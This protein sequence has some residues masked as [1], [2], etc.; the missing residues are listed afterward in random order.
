MKDGKLGVCIVGC[1]AMGTGH[2]T[3]WS[4]VPE[5][6]VVTVVDIDEQR[7]EKLAQAHDLDTWYADYR[8]AVALDEVEVV[9]VCIPTCLHPE[10]TVFAA[11]HGKHVLSEKP[12]ALTLEDA[13]AMIEAARRNGVKLGVGF[14]RRHSPVLPEL[15][16][17]LAE[18]HLGRPVMYHASDIREI[19][20]KREMH[21]AHANGGPVIDMGVHL[22]DLWNYIF[23][24]EP[25]EV[26]AQG[27]KL[28]QDR[29]ELAHIRKIAY[30]TATVVVRYVTGDIGTFVVSW[31]LPPGVVPAPTPDQ[32]LGSKGAAQAMYA[33]AYQQ[34]QVMHEGGEWETVSSSDQNMYQL[35]IARFAHWVLEDEPFPATGEEGKAAL[36]VALAA[37]ESIQTGQPVFL[38]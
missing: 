18:G 8:P 29:S 25:V 27:L 4:Q 35:E 21:D 20:P 15:R 3:W 1:G 38:S 13:D 17:W 24:S 6:Q 14:M 26:F 31:G 2:A 23:D 22:F 11:N 9:S 5:S 28:A 10:V 37:L 33:G 32:I 7:A 19:R 36:R 30:D 16:D 34:V 12:I